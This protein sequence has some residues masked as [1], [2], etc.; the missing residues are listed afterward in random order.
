MFR[1]IEVEIRPESHSVRSVRGQPRRPSEEIFE[2]LACF[3]GRAGTDVTPTPFNSSASL[4]YDWPTLVRN[5]HPQ[6]I[7]FR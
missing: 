1:P 5:R 7:P 3:N 6:T 2:S 4:R